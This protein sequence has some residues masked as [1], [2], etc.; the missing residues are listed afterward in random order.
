[1]M[2]RLF[3]CLLSIVLLFL[4]SCKN[5][6]QEIETKEKP[7]EY[8]VSENQTWKLAN[9]Y[10]NGFEY[11]YEQYLKDSLGL[12][13][14]FL[15]WTRHLV[16]LPLEQCVPMV[17]KFIQDGHNY[18]DMQLR[19]MEL[20]ELFFNDSNSPYRSEA[21][22]I[23]MLETFLATS[24]LEDVYKERYC[25]QLQMAKKNREG[26]LANDFSYVDRVG[27]KGNLYD[28]EGDYIL[29]FFFNPDCNDCG[30]VSSLIQS[31]PYLKELQQQKLLTVMAVYPDKDLTSWNQNVGKYPDT[32]LT[33]RY[34]FDEDRDKYYLSAIP[35]LYLLD[36]DKRVLLKDAPIL[37]I[38]RFLK[39]HIK[40]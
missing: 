25:F 36:K 40:S 7:S 3:G 10:W 14:A 11:D 22:Y 4:F 6:A 9:E 35:T 15:G 34:C 2:M 19:L 31:S 18:P 13:K 30:R 5:I 37:Y 39:A 1:M 32:W 33:V 8:V 29:L 27:N 38:E 26:T 16:K 17:V 28:I 12:S 20:G 21:M 23:P 24:Q